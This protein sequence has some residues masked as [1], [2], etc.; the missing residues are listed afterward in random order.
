LTCVALGRLLIPVHANG[1]PPLKDVIASRA[2][3]VL[4][5]ALDDNDK[6]VAL[7]T[8]HLPKELMHQFRY[9]RPDAR[10][11]IAPNL[12]GKRLED[13]QTGEPTVIVTGPSVERAYGVPEK[14]FRF[15]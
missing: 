2:H 9:F 8:E 4:N 1:D 14:I 12:V 11:R 15:Q 10:Y 5:M 3:S 13:V 6:I 7:D